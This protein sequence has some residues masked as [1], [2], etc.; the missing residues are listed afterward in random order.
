MTI[1][2]LSLMLLWAAPVSLTVAAEPLVSGSRPRH[3]AAQP[4]PQQ[5]LYER[6]G[7]VYPIAVV[8]DDFIDRLLV[9]D[10]LNANAAISE[11]RARVP[12]QGLKFHVTALVCQVTGGPCKYTGR[13][14]TSAH[15]HLHISAKEWQAMLADFR[16]TLNKFGVPAPEQSEL[17]AIVNSTAGE[18]VA[19]TSSPK[20]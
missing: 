14:M 8:V 19:D 1:R 17:I 11:A 7:G 5:S 15:A 6:L 10:T 4:A 2:L 9:N 20:K 16:A 13:D 12:K 18:I 3:L